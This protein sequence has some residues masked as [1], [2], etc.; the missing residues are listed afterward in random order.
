MF[1]KVLVLLTIIIFSLITLLSASQ[2]SI[3]FGERP[4]IDIYK[5]SEGAMEEGWIRIK[6][7]EQYTEHLDNVPVS[8][9]E[10][11]RV[12]FSIPEID[13]LNRYYEVTSITKLFTSPALK[14]D[15]EWRHRQW[16]FH[17]WYEIHYETKEDIRD[18]VMAYRSL[19]S[20]ISWAEPEYKKRLLSES[21]EPLR[22]EPND[23]RL[24]EQWHYNNTGQ[25]NG[26][27]GK[28]ISLFTA[29]DI[30]KGLDDVIVAVIDGGI[31]HNHND[32][33]ANMWPGIGYNF[34]NGSSTIAPHNH[35]THVAGTIAAV[36]NNNTGVAG[37]AGG[38]GSGD[39][40]RLMSCQV[41]TSSSSGGFHLAPVYAADEGAAIS[42]NSWGYTSVGVYD[43]TTLDAIDYF[44][45]NGGGEVMTGGITI[46]AAGN[47]NDNGAWYPGYYAGAFSVA[48]T[49]NQDQKSWYS[50]Y[51]TWVD[52]SA[53]GG[54]TNSVTARGVLST[55][56]NNSYG[57]YQGTSMACPHASGVAA[58]ILSYAYRNGAILTSAEV[59]DLLRDTTDDHYA[60]NP[61]YLGELGTGRLNAH[62]ALLEVTPPDGPFVRLEDYS[63]TGNQSNT[64]QNNEIIDID[65][66]LENIGNEPAYNVLAQLS[67][68]SDEVTILENQENFGTI[69][70]SASVTR[71]NAFQIQTA[72]DIE[73]QTTLAFSILIT[74]GSDSWTSVFSFEVNAPHLDVAGLTIEDPAP[75]GNSNGRLD[76]GETVSMIFNIDNAGQTGS[77]SGT[78]LLEADHPEVTLVSSV[79]NIP[80]LLPGYSAEATY[81]VIIGEG[82]D[83]GTVVDFT[84]TMSYG[85]H[86][87]QYIRSLPVGIVLED[88][89]TGDFSSFPWSFSGNQDWQIVSDTVYEGSYSAKSG[90]IA[91]SQT[92]SMEVTMNIAANGEIS[93]Y[94]KVS[95]E[96]SYDYLRFYID[97]VQQEEWAGE[98]DWSEVSYPV[99]AGERT[100]RW[101]YI[102]DGSVSTGSDCA[103][104]DYIVFPELT[105]D[106]APR[107]LTASAGNGYVTLNWETPQGLSPLSYN[108]YRNSSSLINTELLTYTDNSVVNGLTYEYY[109]TALYT[110][111]ESEPS[112]IVSAT[113][114][115]TINIEIGSG[116]NTNGTTQAAPVNIWYRSLRGQMV[117]TAAEINAAGFSGEGLITHLGFYVT[118]APLHDLPDFLIRM[119]HTTATDASAHDSGPYETVYTS[120]S[121]SP[122]AGG[123]DMI[124][125]SEPFAWNGVDNILVDTAFDRVSSYNSS[126][127]QRIFSVTN[128]FRYTWSD[129]SDQTNANTDTVSSNKPQIK[130]VFQTEDLP[131][132]NPPHSL[133]A[134]PRYNRVE[135]EW[136]AP[137]AARTRAVLRDNAR[138]QILGYNIYRD[139]LRINSETVSDTLYDDNDVSNGESYQYYITA[140]YGIG[141]SE[142][143]NTV[144]AVPYELNTPS[145]LTANLQNHL[146]EL[147]WEAPLP[148]RSGN[149]VRLNSRLVLTGYNV[150]RNDLL[151]NPEPVAEEFFSDN[152]VEPGISYQYFVT[153]LYDEGESNPSNTVEAVPFE[154]PVPY[155]LTAESIEDYV[156]IDWKEPLIGTLIH[157][158]NGE[159]YTG[160]GNNGPLQFKAAIRFSP[161]DLAAMVG[162]DNYLTKISFFPRV[163]NALYELNVW[164]GGT[165]S[166]P[167]TLVLERPVSSLR[168]NSW[169][170]IDLLTPVPI[171][172]EQELW[173][174]YSIDTQ[175]GL[176]AGCD[177][178]PAV[179]GSGNMMFFNG[180]WTTL[181]ASGSSL[182]YNWNIQGLAENPEEEEQRLSRSFDLLGFNLYRDGELL[183]PEPLTTSGHYDHNVVANQTYS[184]YVTALYAEGESDPTET[185]ELTVQYVPEINVNIEEISK[186]IF[187]GETD[188]SLFL[189]NNEGYETLFFNIEITAAGSETLSHPS[190]PNRARE[191]ITWLSVS[192]SQGAVP[193]GDSLWIDIHFNLSDLPDGEYE[194]QLTINSN[195]PETP[196][197]IIPV[198]LTALSPEL[199][200]P[201]NLTVTIENN[202]LT[203]SWDAVLNADYYLVEASSDLDSVFSGIS[204]ERGYF[205][206]EEN[207]ISWTTDISEE[208]SYMF[209]RVKAVRDL[210]GN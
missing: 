134:T 155:G 117:Y 178:G 156:Y 177:S 61:G 184:Y 130:F 100:F 175:T 67:T 168:I 126:G 122:A 191:E 29:W 110:E 107:N 186:E 23:P 35:G 142:A 179:N 40:V 172:T 132:L 109:V 188:D 173:F 68:D 196:Q 37:V 7:Q 63:L 157:W 118:Q 185:V 201:E 2:E 64:P 154:L 129:N 97:G 6:F 25:Q 46:F 90:I 198:Y 131:P 99:T 170:T 133:T 65:L 47:E 60:V 205:S 53:P 111:G 146:V 141:E 143:S 113:P 165:A 203:I 102:K 66:V 209:F 176:P 183:N 103:W 9:D 138:L 28:D 151:L 137:A 56:N 82:I 206:E 49:N 48:A 45:A 79:E 39:G 123:W 42:Q 152:E 16:G 194:A 88:F 193:V 192:P 171:D 101:T 120:A 75:G 22:W 54:E 145:N 11:G 114:A 94:R 98:L 21:I 10:N 163:A 200:V 13:E 195:D 162:P 169:N 197:L 8:R 80:A 31:D 69:A 77:Q 106:D 74:S 89:E 19:E 159:N 108:V 125:L 208:E 148:L 87:S 164:T 150:Y 147:E 140:L 3:R 73:D 36:N 116:T 27:P 139:G 70:A 85:D 55:L 52:I 204:S 14:N 207:R 93:F 33:T 174:G 32:L 84:L 17:L 59:A 135:L 121:Y 86:T 210:S 180:E 43:Q 104:I 158:D 187:T 112:N 95:S 202:V 41:F 136:E 91:H 115:A 92:T 50:T 127:Q 190:S 12:L 153:A 182:D 30:E 167:G 166:E 18:I 105:S 96:S 189:I 38:S 160:I 161:E 181:L 24:D 71:P 83:L 5:V 81:A 44:N 199:A 72:A 4:F 128:G 34:V 26:T 76:P 124:V 58:L 57:F 15:Y 1:R 144:T 149:T 78:A 51:G 20:M 62:A 119:K